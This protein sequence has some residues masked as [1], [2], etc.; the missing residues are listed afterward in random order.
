MASV[1]VSYSRGSETFARRLM[2]TL[3]SRD[4]PFWSDRDIRAGTH[5]ADEIEAAIHQAS[6]FVLVI[7]PDFGTSQWAQFEAGVALGRARES[8]AV[9]I[10]VLLHGA[11]LPPVLRQYQALSV[12]S[13]SLEEIATA[14]QDAAATVRRAHSPLV[15]ELQLFVS[16]PA[17]VV[18]ERECVARVV[19]EINRGIGE[20]SGIRL[21][22]VTW[23][24]TFLPAAAKP[25]AALADW[26]RNTDIFLLILG[27]RLGNA[28]GVGGRTGTEEEFEA[29][30]ADAKLTGRPQMLCY[31]RTS[32]VRVDSMEQ[33]NQMRRILEFR[34]RVR[35][36]NLV[37]EFDSLSEFEE[38]VRYDLTR[39]LTD[40]DRLIQR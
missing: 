20:P 14:V 6:V 22:R 7:S 23:E 15:R 4:T 26:V 37:R 17:D 11:A 35:S 38:L 33:L 30:L 5:W 12:D 40:A 31:I 28:L 27:S 9:V 21:N 8:G 32:A 16:S 3:E 34:D 29:L 24:N 39:L 36:T 1:F 19:D 18:D 2:K 10:P 25:Q 13:A